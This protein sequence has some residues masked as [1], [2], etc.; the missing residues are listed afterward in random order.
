M[1]ILSSFRKLPWQ[2]FTLKIVLNQ[3]AN[4]SVFANYIKTQLHGRI[5]YKLHSLTRDLIKESEVNTKLKKE[6]LLS[7]QIFYTVSVLL[8][9]FQ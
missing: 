2:I 8:L 6:L 7:N 3:F 4:K 9:G 1:E 5:I